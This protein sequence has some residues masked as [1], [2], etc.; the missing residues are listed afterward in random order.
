M[1]PEDIIPLMQHSAV[2]HTRLAHEVFAALS[3]RT[4]LAVAQP[5][6]APHRGAD[7]FKIKT[8]TFVTG[9]R[10]NSGQY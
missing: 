1:H 7:I 10:K 2:V 5:E 9:V 6:K 4:K 8:F 3:R